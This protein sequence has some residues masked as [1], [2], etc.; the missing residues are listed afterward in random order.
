[1]SFQLLGIMRKHILL[2]EPPAKARSG[3][4]VFLQVASA[5][6]RCTRNKQPIFPNMLK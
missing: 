5:I 6:A 1:M 4:K 2:V 3:G